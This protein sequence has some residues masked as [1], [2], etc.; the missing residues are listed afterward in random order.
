MGGGGKQVPFAVVI[1]CCRQGQ[2][3]EQQPLKSHQHPQHDGR[4]CTPSGHICPASP[5]QAE[6]QQT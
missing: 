1:Q 2:N 5:V 4:G 3:E 6:L